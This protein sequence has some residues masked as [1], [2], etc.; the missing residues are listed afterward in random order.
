MISAVSKTT[1]YLVWEIP[2]GSYNLQRNDRRAQ[3]AGSDKVSGAGGGGERK[4]DWVGGVK[5]RRRGGGWEVGG[6]GEAGRRR[7][8]R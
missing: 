2:S 3:V 5:R 6:G 8:G 7:R 4:G 1:G